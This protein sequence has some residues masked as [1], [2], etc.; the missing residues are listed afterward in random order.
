MNEISKLRTENSQLRTENQHLSEEVD[1]L[2][3]AVK[4]Y[5]ALVN[6]LQSRQN[7]LYDDQCAAKWRR[8]RNEVE[9]WTRHYF[10]NRNVMDSMSTDTVHARRIRAHED[11]FKTPHGRLSYIKGTIARMIFDSI[12]KHDFVYSPE[13]ADGLFRKLTNRVKELGN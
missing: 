9:I 8:L 5:T 7:I 3:E 1:R 11:I 2:R 10:S 4:D 6:S 13:R 12:F